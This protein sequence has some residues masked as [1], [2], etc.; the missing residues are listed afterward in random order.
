MQK[1]FLVSVACG[2]LSAIMTSAILLNSGVGII[3]GYLGLL[4]IMSVGLATGLRYLTITS[5]VCIASL[6]L[7]SNQ[8]QVTLY[9]FSM[10]IPSFLMCYLVLNRQYINNIS[11]DW[12]DIGHVVS[13]M[14]VLAI[15]YL[16]AGA[17]FLTEG[18]YDLENHI[19]GMLN[20]IFSERMQIASVLDRKL[21]ISTIIPYFPALIAS[22]WLIMILINAVL[23]QSLLTKIHKNIRPRVKYSL[24][25]APQWTYWVF[26]FFG[27]ASLFGSGKIEFITQNACLISA[28]PFFLIG[29]TV[30]NHLAKRTKAP[31]T[32]LF[33]F[34]IFLSISSW[35]IA[36]CTII[37]FFE[38]WLKLREKYKRE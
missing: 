30:F 29:L 17:A 1:E 5:C 22:S 27:L 9:F 13:A 35:A 36:I 32:I 15:I 14:T 19:K 28:I 6:L 8:A 37:G 38:E 26:T 11:S 18:S 16:L 20:K 4:P 10:V 33:I 23:A 2:L 34:Y 25:F 7:F 24:L 12:R 3:L 31:K 21:L